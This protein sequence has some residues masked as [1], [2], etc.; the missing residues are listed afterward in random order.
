MSDLDRF[1]I[2][3]HVAQTCS[4]SQTAKHLQ[5]TKASLSKQIKKL[6]ADLGVDLFSRTGRRFYLT[7]HGEILLQQ[8]LRLKKELE[9]TRAI[10]ENFHAI[11]KGVLHIVALDFFA[12]KLIYP[13]LKE[14]MKKYPELDIILDI[15]ERIPDFEQEQVDIAVG[16][17][18]IAPDN[19]IQRSFATTRH[20]MCASPEYLKK[21]GTPQSLPDLLKHRYI[22]HRGRNEVCNTHLKT[23]YEIKIKPSLVLNSVIGMIECAKAGLGIVQ[24]PFYLVEKLLNSGKL[25]EVLSSYQTIDAPVYYFYP[26]FRHTQPKIQCF[27]DFFLSR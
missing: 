25:V 21:F 27:I 10:C 20:V 15:S 11:P 13:R 6:E 14:F 23:G 2:F 1:E 5:V 8:C 18:L 4:L 22:G 7:N 9:D 17:S 24:L 12:Q 3:T 16:F 19:V 26:K